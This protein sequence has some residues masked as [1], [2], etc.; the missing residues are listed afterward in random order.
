[1]KIASATGVLMTGACFPL[2]PTEITVRTETSDGFSSLSL[3][4][5]R[6]SVMIEITINPEVK[7][8]LKQ[9]VK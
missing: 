8:M 4:D 7:R 5:D 9:L 2:Q 3:S 1:M 6:M